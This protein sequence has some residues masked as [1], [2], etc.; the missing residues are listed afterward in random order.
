VHAAV[1]FLVVDHQLVA[2]HPHALGGTQPDDLFLDVELAPVAAGEG[3]RVGFQLASDVS[4]DRFLIDAD[5][6]APGADEGHI[7]AGDRSHAAVRAA[8][9]FELELV[10][11]SRPVQLVLVII[12]QREAQRLGVVAGILAA[13]FSD[14]VGG[15]AQ[16][17]AR[18]TQVLVQLVG[19]L[20]ENLLELRS[21]SAQE[22]DV[23][24]G[25]V[26]V[27]DAAAA[28]IP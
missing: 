27:G 17:G 4:L 7:S 24:G 22:N 14:A 25:A 23:P 28:K 12:G 16:V 9:K 3:A 18:A 20:V 21:G 26:H 15:G 13:G 11:K 19:Q 1:A 2:L 8:V 6:V 10:G 5:V